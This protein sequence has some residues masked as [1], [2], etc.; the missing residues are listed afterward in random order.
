MSKINSV[1][2]GYIN[3][4]IDYI[5]E[6]KNSAQRAKARAFMEY[7]DDM[8]SGSVNAFSFYAQSWGISK[9]QVQTWIKDFRNEIDRFFSYWALKNSAHYNSVQKTTDRRPT[10]DRPTNTSKTPIESSFIKNDRPTTDRRP[11]EAFNLN[12]DDSARGRVDFFDPKFEDLYFRARL[13]N[14]KAGNK[15]DAYEEYTEHHTHISHSDMAYAYMVYANDPQTNGKVFNLV[16][17][18]KNQVYLSYLTPRIRVLKNGNIIEGWYDKE[19]NLLTTED[20]TEWILK[21]DRFSELVAK[22][23]ITILQKMRAAV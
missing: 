2:M 12:D 6:L 21:P 11:T 9:T 16:N 3:I 14:K 20:K 8:D 1:R 15:K 17:F 23:D 7:F 5:R 22:G 19:K 4:P 18:L 10:D 13:C